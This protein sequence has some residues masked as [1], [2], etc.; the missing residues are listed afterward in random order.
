MRYFIS[1]ITTIKCF[2]QLSP[3]KF[4]RRFIKALV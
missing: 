4:D 2:Q 1:Q 3:K